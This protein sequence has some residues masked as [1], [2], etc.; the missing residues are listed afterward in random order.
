VRRE[1]EEEEEET[2]RKHAILTK[3]SQQRPAK[4]KAGE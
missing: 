1:E 3:Y 4:R 2:A